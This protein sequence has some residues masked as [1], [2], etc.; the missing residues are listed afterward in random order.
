MS[1]ANV[2]FLITPTQSDTK[3]HDN[4]L[5]DPLSMGMPI[6]NKSE[7]IRVCVCM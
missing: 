1:F 7:D 5:E 6:L 4:E 2:S 3:W